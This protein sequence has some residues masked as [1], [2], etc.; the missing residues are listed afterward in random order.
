MTNFDSGKTAP[1]LE[2][3]S[4][5]KQTAALKPTK[6]GK[7]EQPPDSMSVGDVTDSKTQQKV[8]DKL[9]QV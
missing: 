5:E 3:S 8:A 9:N 2:D 7:Q 1:L 4:Q 6:E